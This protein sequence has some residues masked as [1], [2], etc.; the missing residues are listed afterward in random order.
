ML[1][2]NLY[3]HIALSTIDYYSRMIDIHMEQTN[4]SVNLNRVSAIES[5]GANLCCHGSLDELEN[6]LKSFKC[7]FTEF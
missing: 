1:K 4:L 2:I 7:I 3:L 6:C 5:I